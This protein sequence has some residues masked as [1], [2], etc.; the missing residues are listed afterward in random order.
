MRVIR[1]AELHTYVLN[2]RSQ[3]VPGLKEY[4]TSLGMGPA[5]AHHPQC[6]RQSWGRPSGRRPRLASVSDT[7]AANSTQQGAPLG[8][9]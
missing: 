8:A 5:A 9:T 7:R 1:G 3:T 6:V 2:V 4:H